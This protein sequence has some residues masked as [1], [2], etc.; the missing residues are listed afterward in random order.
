MTFGRMLGCEPIFHVYGAMPT[1]NID[2]YKNYQL[3]F[4]IELK[5]ATSNE[6]KFKYFG[7]FK[8]SNYIVFNNA[9]ETSK[10]K[11]KAF[12]LKFHLMFN[13]EIICSQNLDIAEMHDCT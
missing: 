11:N 1:K 7:P 12:Q 13:Q 8:I 2:R 4:D 5:E 10:M 6:Y 3:G 9:F